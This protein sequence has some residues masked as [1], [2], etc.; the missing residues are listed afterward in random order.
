MS[1]NVNNSKRLYAY[2]TPPTASAT[3]TNRKGLTELGKDKLSVPGSAHDVIVAGK[4]RVTCWKWQ[5]RTTDTS[6]RELYPRA[7]D[8]FLMSSSTMLRTWIGP[9]KA[10]GLSTFACLMI[11]VSRG[12]HACNK[13]GPGCERNTFRTFSK[14]KKTH[15]HD[16]V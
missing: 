1:P 5:T 14:K 2:V 8:V 9:F 7:R 15:R 16:L 4:G 3:S 6:D 10:P 11:T 13:F 12:H